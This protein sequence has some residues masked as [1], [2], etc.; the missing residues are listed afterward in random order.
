MRYINPRFT[1]LLTY[2]VAS[3]NQIFRPSTNLCKI[4]RIGCST[5]FATMIDT[6]YTISSHHLIKQQ[7][8]TISALLHHTRDCYLRVQAPMQILSLDHCIR[9]QY[10]VR[11][12]NINT[13]TRKTQRFDFMSVLHM[14]SNL[15]FY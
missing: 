5:D 1:Y 3:V 9:T 11:G 15:L 7:N 2:A 8:T 4:L 12:R 13:L 10:T 6:P 14:Y